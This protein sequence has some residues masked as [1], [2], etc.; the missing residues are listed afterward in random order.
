MLRKE[1]Q[2]YP[3][4]PGL[5]VKWREFIFPASYDGVAMKC[6]VYLV[7]HQQLFGAF[8]GVT[9]WGQN[10]AN[11]SLCALANCWLAQFGQLVR[12]INELGAE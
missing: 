9:K 4:K 6:N 3:A 1:V 12:S 10:S 7:K 8:H 2:V 11:K 5:M